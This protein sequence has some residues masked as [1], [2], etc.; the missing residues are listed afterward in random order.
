M[1]R[2][3]R[4]VGAA[5]MRGPPS[6]TTAVDAWV[7]VREWVDRMAV[8]PNAGSPEGVAAAAVVLRLDG[9]PVGVGTSHEKGSSLPRAVAQAIERVRQD[10]VIEGLSTKEQDAVGRRLTMELEL[11]GPAAPDGG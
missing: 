2:S 1:G 6:T 8:P 7:T 4:T 9:R 5:R 3:R 10:R 11:A